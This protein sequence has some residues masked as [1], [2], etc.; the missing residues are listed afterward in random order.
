MAASRATPREYGLKVQSHPVLMVTSSIKM[1]TARD[2]ELSFSGG[3]SETINFHREPAILQRNLE[4]ARRL[5][6]ALG[7]P[8]TNPRR[9]R[10]GKEHVWNGH[11]WSGVPAE[12]VL[13][14]LEAY[15][16]H[17]EARKANSLLLAEFIRSLVAEGELTD[18]TIALIGGGEG[19]TL[20]LGKDVSV[21]MLQRSAHGDHTDRYSIRRL[22]S[23]RDEAIDLDEAPWLLALAETQKAFHADAGRNTSKEEPD[24]P[25]GPA[26]RRVRPKER[27]VLFIYAIDPALAGADA[28]LPKDTPPVIALAASFPASRSGTRVK[29]RV[30]NV[31]WELEYG[32]ID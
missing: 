3:L 12:C 17:P 10:G 15:R 28:K 14:F 4:A 24:V 8:E 23:P 30:N 11:V 20:S 26:I 2:L 13:D 29:Y 27:G 7:T 1:R 6:S 5:F 18:W 32:G 25:N 22:M 16:S 19:A 9:P 21:E 31:F